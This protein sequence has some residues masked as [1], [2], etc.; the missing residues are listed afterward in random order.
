MK[1]L[2]MTNNSSSTSIIVTET[3]HFA[4]NSKLRKKNG[5]VSV[6]QIVLIENGECL[7]NNPLEHEENQKS[8]LPQKSWSNNFNQN[9]KIS[10]ERSEKG[11]LGKG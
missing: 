3:V 8:K 1:E 6:L 2:Y 7:K 4:I 5:Q 11:S 9:G 10:K